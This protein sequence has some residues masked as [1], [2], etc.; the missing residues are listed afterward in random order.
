MVTN[1]ELI[2]EIHK[3]GF[4]LEEIASANVPEGTA[5]KK[6]YADLLLHRIKINSL[7]RKIAKLTNLVSSSDGAERIKY[8]AQIQE[9]NNKINELQQQSIRG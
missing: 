4:D 2:N 3:C 5:N 1:D 6:E 7:K 8:L 9:V